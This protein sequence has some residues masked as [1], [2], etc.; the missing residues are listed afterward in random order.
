M[1]YAEATSLLSCSSSSLKRQQLC[2]EQTEKC[3]AVGDNGDKGDVK[4]GCG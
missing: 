4:M 1:P 3:G 2:L